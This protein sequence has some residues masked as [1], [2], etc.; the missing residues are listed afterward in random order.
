MRNLL[1]VRTDEV[2]EGVAQIH[3]GMNREELARMKSLYMTGTELRAPG[4]A[5]ALLSKAFQI[6]KMDGNRGRFGVVVLEFS[7]D[8]AD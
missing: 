7:N 1:K 4:I 6:A 8:N 2:I 5:P 3:P